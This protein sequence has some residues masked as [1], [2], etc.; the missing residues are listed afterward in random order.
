MSLRPR[1][2]LG[3]GLVASFLFAP[4]F[5]GCAKKKASAIVVSLSSEAPIPEELDQME[6]LV[7]RGDDTRHLG[8]YNLDVAKTGDTRLPG[9]LTLQ[10]DDGE[11]GSA[12]V[13]ITITASSGS[14][15]RV[16]RRATLGFSDEKT[17]LLKMP[18][19]YSCFDFKDVCSATEECVGGVCTDTKIDVET[20]P[21]Y[22][23]KLVFGTT[24]DKSCFDDTDAGCFANASTLEAP[25]TA[26]TDAADGTCA[27]KLGQAATGGTGLNVALRWSASTSLGRFAT[28]DV[29]TDGLRE[30]FSHDGSGTVKLP[31]GICAAIKDGRVT[32]VRTSTACATKTGS[33]PLCVFQPTSCKADKKPASLATSACFQCLYAPSAPKN[34]AALLDEARCDDASRDYLACLLDSPFSNF[35]KP[36]D[37]PEPRRDA[38]APKLGDCAT[39]LNSAACQ[40]KYAKLLAYVACADEVN[41]GLPDDTTQDLAAALA[42]CQEPCAKDGYIASCTQSTAF[43]APLPPGMY[44]DGKGNSV[45]VTASSVALQFAGNARIVLSTTNAQPTTDPAITRYDAKVM[46]ASSVPM[47]V[48]GGWP[49]GTTVTTS[50]PAF[51]WVSTKGSSSFIDLT[52]AT[53]TA[54]GT[55]FMAGGPFTMGGSEPACATA[56]A[57]K[58]IF[59]AGNNALVTCDPTTKQIT[60]T[61]ACP[62]GCKTMGGANDAC[63]A[64]PI[65]GCGNGVVDA[66]ETC[67]DGGTANGDGCT[68]NCL[69]EPN[70]ICKGTPS[71]C[72]MPAGACGA[73]VAMTTC[74]EVACSVGLCPTCITQFFGGMTLDPGCATDPQFALF[75]A[76]TC[77]TCGSPCTSCL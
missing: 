39:N 16:L 52:L 61:Q 14:K 71:K 23:D 4:V 21:D 74:N 62:G 13:T 18:L 64:P 32:G 55:G 42:R 43:V 68:N 12:P 54:P 75:K 73:C 35:S 24:A 63:A 3:F 27:L 19:R 11:D 22:T 45:I 36:A 28:L 49:T 30:G 72:T 47:M 65:E 60:G 6:V 7:Q 57:T 66:T 31:K 69:V 50:T 17:K 33:Q 70:Y 29:E 1:R 41:G 15:K 40:Q 8:Q 26:L 34:C 48:P 46:S 51:L 67:D 2:V 56:S 58:F 20:L 44:A 38:C 76:C 53:A 25:A 37:C 10:K 77:G 9:T 59:C 5:T